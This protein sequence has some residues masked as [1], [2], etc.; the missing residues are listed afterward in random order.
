LRRSGER[1]AVALSREM[2]LLAAVCEMSLVALTA[3][4]CRL[5]VVPSAALENG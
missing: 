3:R 2:V 5:I 4:T 1:A